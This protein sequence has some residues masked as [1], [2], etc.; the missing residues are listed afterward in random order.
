M[1]A[2]KKIA[3]AFNFGKFFPSMQGK[4][5]THAFSRTS[6][7]SKLGHSIHRESIATR[8]QPT[9]VHRL[10]TKPPADASVVAVPMDSSILSPISP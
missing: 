8:V 10:P 5:M 4:K 9:A 2:I 6:V 3:V 7:N 1:Q